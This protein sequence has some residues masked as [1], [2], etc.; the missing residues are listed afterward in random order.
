MP[1]C[2][3]FCTHTHKYVLK[4]VNVN[5]NKVMWM[6]SVFTNRI[7]IYTKTTTRTR[8]CCVD[9]WMKKY[10]KKSHDSYFVCFEKK[11]FRCHNLCHILSVFTPKN[12]GVLLWQSLMLWRLNLM[13]NRLKLTFLFT[14]ITISDFN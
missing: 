10:T 9:C 14:F 3:Y 12:Y 1:S 7:L 8:V 4:S 5:Q 6:H 11:V 13:I 2:Y